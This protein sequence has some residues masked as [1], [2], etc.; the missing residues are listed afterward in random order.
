[1]SK[2]LQE[3]AQTT[4]QGEA[5]EIRQL[6]LPAHQQAAARSEPGKG[7]LD[8]P[9]MTITAQRTTILSDVF[10]ASILAVRRDHFQPEFGESF[11][12]FVTVISLVADQTL[13]WSLF[14]KE[15]E[16]LLLH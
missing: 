1:M 7:A 16:G 4:E 14:G 8:N 12:E 5:D 3:Q 13:G 2:S 10:R 6:L 15:I 9:A 11:I